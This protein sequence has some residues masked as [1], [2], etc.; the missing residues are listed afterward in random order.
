[1]TSNMTHLVKTY[2]H[3]WQSAVNPVD[4]ASQNSSAASINLHLLQLL[5][6]AVYKN[7]RLFLVTM[8][9][10]VMH[11]PTTYMTTM[12]TV[13]S[14][15]TAVMQHAARWCWQHFTTHSRTHCIDTHS[16]IVPW[17]GETQLSVLY[18][19][20]W[21][22]LTYRTLSRWD[23][24]VSSV[25][26]A[27]THTH[28]HIVPW[29]GESYLEQVRHSGQFCTHCID[30]HSH[31]VPWAGET[32]SSVLY[33]LHW[34]TLTLTHCTLSRWIIPWAGETQWSVL[35]CCQLSLAHHDCLTPVSAQQVY[36]PHS[37]SYQFNCADPY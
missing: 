2:Y 11:W 5:C 23:T 20:H 17:A 29:A 27:L 21:H 8:L 1:M 37:I 25:H 6:K 15:A 32:Q 30:T 14:H 28:S 26:T 33:T 36:T 4:T 13:I 19:L 22:T 31:I 18:T 34:H 7:R 16:H 35:Q 3:I 12:M 10:R 9:T 24:V